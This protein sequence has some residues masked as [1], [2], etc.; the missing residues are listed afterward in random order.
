[1]FLADSTD[2]KRGGDVYMIPVAPF[3]EDGVLYVPLNA[4]AYIAGLNYSQND[5]G[6]AIISAAD[7]SDGEKLSPALNDLYLSY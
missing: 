1:M 4:A 5:L 7:L 2:V 6:V 3:V